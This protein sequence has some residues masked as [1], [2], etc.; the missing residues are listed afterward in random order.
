MCPFSPAGHGLL[1]III[2]VF[3]AVPLYAQITGTIKD[4]K[5]K[6][7]VEGVEIFL[8][9]T[10]HMAVSDAAGIFELRGL[11]PGFADIGLY[12][13]GYKLFKSS[14]RLQKGKAYALNLSIDRAPREGS[15]RVRDN[16]TEQGLQ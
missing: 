4:S 13:K 5:S 9:G 14:L 2:W 16:N 15:G 8:L 6:K 3:I 7:P 1:F 10:T 11:S 12:R